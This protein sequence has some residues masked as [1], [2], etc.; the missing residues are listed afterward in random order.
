MDLDSFYFSLRNL[1]LASHAHQW[2]SLVYCSQ[3]KIVYEKTLRHVQ[4]GARCLDWGCGNG[5]F[6]YF[7]AHSGFE[8]D[9]YTLDDRPALL[10]FDDIAFTKG[11]DP[12]ALP[13]PDDTFDAAFS[14]GVLEHVHERGG[15]RARTVAELARVLKPSGLLLAFHLPKAASW[16]EF[17]KGAVGALQHDKRFRRSEL[18]RLFAGFEIVESGSY[19]F[20]PR[21]VL[22]AT[23]L[24]DSS[25]FCAAVNG[26]DAALSWLLRPIC[27]NWYFILRKPITS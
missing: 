15:D 2:Q 7:L 24:R 3:E 14:V 27:Q 5:H 21:R 17:S 12:I 10:A 20:L 8:V 16:L 11:S 18:K 22:A 25:A 6:S 26:A 19:H 1:G 9:A 4:R 23:P 13:Y